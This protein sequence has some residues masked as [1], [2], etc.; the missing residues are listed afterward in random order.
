MSTERNGR[1]A[2]GERER[3]H[4][5]ANRPHWLHRNPLLDLPGVTHGWTCSQG[6][7]FHHPVDAPAMTGAVSRLA[8]VSGKWRG[9][10][11]EQV[12]GG[13]VLQAAGPGLAGAADALWTDSP[14][15]GV[16]GRSA[17]CPLILVAGTGPDQAP[18][19]GFAHASWRSTV[20]NIT[21]H[22]LEQMTAAGFQPAGARALICPSAGPCCY[23]V[24][25]EVRQEALDRLGTGATSLFRLHKDRWILDLWQANLRQLREGGLSAENIL[26]SGE[27]TICGG[28]A[29]GRHYPS[30]RRQGHSAGRFAAM[31][32]IEPGA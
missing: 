6:P 26:S 28:G 30:Y 5:A 3:S 14:G 24:G 25:D 1:D 21:S 13:T 27:C 18:M 23:E 8:E 4:P 17:D 15:L 20:R 2:P 10:W 11:A 16:V 19:V 31:V 29:S 22:L 7:D 9:A 12:H 32:G